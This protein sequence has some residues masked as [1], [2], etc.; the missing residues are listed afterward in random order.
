MTIKWLVQNVGFSKTNLDLTEETLTRMSLPY[1]VFGI[2]RLI[3]YVINLE[4]ILT[5]PEEKFIIRG[6]TSLLSLLNKITDLNEINPNMSEKKLQISDI[7]INNLKEGIFYN[8]ESFDQNYYG[9]LDL[10]LLNNKSQNLLIK[11][12]LNA[13]F[14]RP[15]FIKPSRDQKAFNAG[16]LEP[17]YTIKDFI[18]SQLHESF[19][20]EET[21]IVAPVKSIYAE[22]RFFVVDKEIITCSQYRNSHSLFVS[23][24]VPE[25]IQEAAKEYAK[26]YQ[27]H[28]IF[29]MDLADT[30]EGIKI[31]EYNCWNASGLYQTNVSKIFNVVHEFIEAKN[32]PNHKLGLKN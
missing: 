8:E 17:G 31:I 18:F 7:Y 25:S 19:Y 20:I 24:I 11:D 9:K 21:A 23:D 5:N 22:Y 4:N 14:D 30:P 26:L 10:P 15:V 28:D 12:N 1:D 13:S 27:P 16:I 6:G 2:S 32:K 3:N 29:T